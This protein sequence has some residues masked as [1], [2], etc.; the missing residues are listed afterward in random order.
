MVKVIV[1]REETFEIPNSCK[2]C[3]MLR[4][5]QDGNA[6]IATCKLKNAD[7]YNNTVEY[8]ASGW[9]NK[10]NRW[11]WFDKDRYFRDKDCPLEDG[12]IYSLN[13]WE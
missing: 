10:E 2:D 9:F 3:P 5:E 11:T 4:H 7:G 12:H 6:S 13:N 8:K 1:H